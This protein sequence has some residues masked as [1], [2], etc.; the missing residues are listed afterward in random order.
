MIVHNNGC[1]SKSSHYSL[2]FLHQFNTLEGLPT[3][4]GQKNEENIFCTEII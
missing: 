4:N 1:S 2:Y 3:G